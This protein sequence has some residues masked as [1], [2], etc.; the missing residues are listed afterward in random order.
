VGWR[1]SNC[2]G[3]NT[4]KVFLSERSKF[5]VEFEETFV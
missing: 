5:S 4:A 1:N 2:S 3:G